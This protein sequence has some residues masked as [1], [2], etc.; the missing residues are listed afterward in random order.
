M[1][2]NYHIFVNYVTKKR[3][4]Y[5]LCAPI[6]PKFCALILPLFCMG[7]QW[8]P[9]FSGLQKY[10]FEVRTRP[11]VGCRLPKAG[12]TD[13]DR[14]R[15]S[16]VPPI[17]LNCRRSP[18]VRGKPRMPRRGARNLFIPTQT[19]ISR[20]D[21]IRKTDKERATTGR[22]YYGV[23][24]KNVLCTNIHIKEEIRHVYGRYRA[25]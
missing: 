15:I 23:N 8:S 6:L 20:L 22:P 4:T 17:L 5:H 21:F 9:A 19:D 7:D 12:G 24:A 11:R 16:S 18:H 14:R 25:R 10:G 13:G 1:S 3:F 2:S